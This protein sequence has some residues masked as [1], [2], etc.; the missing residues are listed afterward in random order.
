[1]T[2]DETHQVEETPLMFSRCSSLGSLSSF[3][4]Q[5]VHSS[6]VSEH[7]RRASQVV[8]PSEL[9]DSPSETMPPSPTRVQSPPARSFKPVAMDLV[10]ESSAP[11]AGGVGLKGGHGDD[12]VRK[13]T[14][15]V[16]VC[17]SVCVLV[18]LCVCKFIYLHVFA[19]GLCYLKVSIFFLPSIFFFCI[20][21]KPR[22]QDI[23]L[24]GDVFAARESSC[25][26][27]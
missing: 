13:S 17:V 26:Y 8:S 11:A 5:S 16:C 22:E 12:K 1:M 10:G 2:F 9:P 27:F 19:F 7:S 21:F 6:L 18:S 23:D 15:C 3:D 24:H 20:T 4:T 25:F 14:G